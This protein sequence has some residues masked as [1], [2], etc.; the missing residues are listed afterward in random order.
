MSESLKK[1]VSS[2]MKS[3]IKNIKMTIRHIQNVWIETLKNM[4]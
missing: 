2:G 3:G 1:V 4:V